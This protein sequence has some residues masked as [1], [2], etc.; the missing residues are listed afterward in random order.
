[1]SK[2]YKISDFCE[3]QIQ[4]VFEHRNGNTILWKKQ[5]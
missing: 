4:E 5:K 3:E 1:M 2:I